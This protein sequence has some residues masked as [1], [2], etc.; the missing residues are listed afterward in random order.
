[1]ATKGVRAMEIERN[2]LIELLKVAIMSGQFEPDTEPNII[3][4]K[5]LKRIRGE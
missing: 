1:M 4:E 5:L 3:L 2:T